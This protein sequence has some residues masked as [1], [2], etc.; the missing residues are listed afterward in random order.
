MGS[1]LG[2]EGWG[3]KVKLD[4]SVSVLRNLHRYGVYST[5][6]EDTVPGCW[7]EP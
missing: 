7:K 1:C 3:T 2:R 6:F 5:R 4:V